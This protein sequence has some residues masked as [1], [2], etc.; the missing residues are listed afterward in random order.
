MPIL[1]IQVVVHPGEEVPT[2]RAGALADAAGRA[3]GSPPGRTWVRLESLAA[4]HYAE[5]EVAPSDTPLP[6]FVT[7]LMARPP[8][9]DARRAQAAMLAGALAETLGRPRDLVHIVYQPPGAG[10][11]AFGGVL[12]E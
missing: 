10:R 11:V 3:L 8:R 2:G 9:G 12:V 7:I 4:T 5:N 6:V 1:A